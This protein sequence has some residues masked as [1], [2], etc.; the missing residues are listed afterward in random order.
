ME[1]SPDRVMGG[2]L[3]WSAALQHCVMGRGSLS[4]T[5]VLQNHVVE[6]A[7]VDCCLLVQPCRPLESRK[8][9]W[10]NK[11]GR[12]KELGGVWE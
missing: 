9:G 1:P 3:M 11:D 10:R 2:K 8:T 4:Q 6:I 5:A 7:A 12:G